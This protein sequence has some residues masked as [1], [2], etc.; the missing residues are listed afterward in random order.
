MRDLLPVGEASVEARVAW[1]VTEE[2]LAER[3]R[4]HLGTI[5]VVE[6]YF[7]SR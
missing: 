7:S 6:S 2:Q 1:R 3:L 5:A 4:R